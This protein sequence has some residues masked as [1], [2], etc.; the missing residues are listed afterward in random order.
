MR[1]SHLVS[2]LTPDLAKDLSCRS[3]AAVRTTLID[4]TFACGWP[5]EPTKD[6][7]MPNTVAFPDGRVLCLAMPPANTAEWRSHPETW[8]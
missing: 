7:S 2:V 3:H 4:D 6:G 5:D 8:R 1:R